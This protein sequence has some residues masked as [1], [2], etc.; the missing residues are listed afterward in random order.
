MYKLLIIAAILFLGPLSSEASSWAPFDFTSEYLPIG[1]I[2]KPNSIGSPYCSGD[3]ISRNLVLTARHCMFSTN[4]DYFFKPG[5]GSDFDIDSVKVKGFKTYGSGPFPGNDWL[6]LIL[7]ENLGNDVGWLELSRDNYSPEIELVGYPKSYKDG[8]KAVRSFD[9]K[10]KSYFTNYENNFVQHSCLSNKG[11]SGAPVLTRNK[12][13][14]LVI[15]GLHVGDYEGSNVAVSGK[16]LTE[17]VDKYSSE[18]QR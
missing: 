17:F 8:T 10:I 13:G 4:G 5:F 14:K 9:C 18:S 11:M 3:L 15:V 16:K 1:R 2:Y 7:S 12:S 6:I